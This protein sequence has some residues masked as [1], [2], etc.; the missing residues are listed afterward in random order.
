MRE[1]TVESMRRGVEGSDIIVA[2]VSPAY[3][4]SINCGKEMG[5][6]AQAGKVVVPIV[7]GVPYTEWPP[8][9]IG[10]TPM[11]TQFETLDGDQKLF[12]E[13]TDKHSFFTKLNRELLPRLLPQRADLPS[14]V[15]AAASDQG[16]PAARARLSRPGMSRR[17]TGSKV[18]P[19]EQPDEE[20]RGDCFKC[21]MPVLTSQ[22]RDIDGA[23]RY[24]HRVCPS[25]C[26]NRRLTLASDW[27]KPGS[28]IPLP[29]PPAVAW[30]TA[31]GATRK[32][33]F[34]KSAA[35]HSS[36]GL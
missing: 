10:E 19:A 26:V 8:K 17:K 11:Q 1:W 5:F 14:L 13:M 21:R 32:P 28:P 9:I 36:G 35:N 22:E 33:R 25:T 18:T 2:V 34:I 24:Y 23:G 30:A 29:P 27:W 7:L 4:A 15:T 12:V 31:T 6:A 16:Q 3:V 20:S